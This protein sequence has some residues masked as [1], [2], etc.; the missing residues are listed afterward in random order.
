MIKHVSKQPIFI[1]I[2]SEDTRLYNN[3]SGK[4]YFHSV[5]NNAAAF[6]REEG[7]L[8]NFDSPP[9]YLAYY[10][11]SSYHDGVW[12]FQPSADFIENTD[13]GWIY[14]ETKGKR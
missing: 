1:S 13:E 2:Q 3:L 12:L 9:Y 5:K 11:A 7:Q 10:D 6:V 14:I 8:K 4:Y